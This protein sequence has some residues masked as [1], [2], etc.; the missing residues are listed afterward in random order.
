MD[1]TVAALGI[2]TVALVILAVVLAILG[3]LLP[4]FVY[5]IATWTRQ[6]KEELVRTNRHL[7]TIV[8]RL[9]SQAKQ[10]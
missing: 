3:I 5:R 7:A 1:E 8:G 2:A 9:D 4:W 6:T 10:R